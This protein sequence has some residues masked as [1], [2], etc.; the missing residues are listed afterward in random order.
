MERLRYE[1]VLTEDIPAVVGIERESFTTADPDFEVE[2]LDPGAWD[3]ETVELVLREPRT[4]CL[5]VS[6]EEGVAVGWFCY[7]LE[8]NGVLVRRLLVLPAWRKKDV[9]RT[10]LYKLYKLVSRSER[11]RTLRMYVPLTDV[12]TCQYL[13][14]MQFDSKLV[15]DGWD[16][17]VDAVLF[18]FTAGENEDWPERAAR[19]DTEGE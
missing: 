2:C 3:E 1:D 9:G 6:N 15:R 18:H 12:A 16:D 13:A 8:G 17:G 7:E 14:H 10:V 11:R 5:I 4:R 19:S